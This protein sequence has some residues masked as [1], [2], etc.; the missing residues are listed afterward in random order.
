MIPVYTGILS[1]LPPVLTIVLAIITKEVVVSLLVGIFSGSI[2]YC[3]ATQSAFLEAVKIVFV[4]MSKSI[5]ENIYIIIFG[6]MLGA[7]VHVITIAGGS[8]AYGKWAIEKIKSRKAVQIATAFLGIFLAIDDYFNCL[9]VGTV[10]RPITDKH[11]V[12]RAKFAYI[13]D[14]M[15]APVCVIAPISSWAASIVSCLENAELNGMTM[16]IR[17]IPYNFYAILTICFVFMLCLSGIDFGPMK[18]FEYNALVKGDLFTT[19]PEEIDK[20]EEY[21]YISEKGTVWDLLLPVI[22]L[23][24]V[25][26]LMMLETG[27]FF[28]G[29]TTFYHALGSTNSGLSITVGAVSALLAAFLMFVPRK[30]LSFK[31]FMDGVNQGMKSMVPAF[32]ILAL[33]WTMSDICGELIC[34]GVYISDL[35]ASSNVDPAYIPVFVFLVSG[36]LSFS[37]GTSWGTFGILIPVVA[38][39]CQKFSPEITV[40]ALSATLS[41]AVFGDHCSPISDT[42]VLSSMGAGCNHMDHVSSQMPYA[43]LVAFCSLIGYIL[44]GFTQ[45]AIISVFF[46]LMAMIIIAAVI[47]KKFRSKNINME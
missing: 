47:Y 11:R 1:V 9:T 37:L 43:C 6:S 30:V 26:M 31:V 15:A 22:V 29:G 39:I 44:A 2:I 19:R 23:I 45:S 16:F 46:A 4:V 27:G 25:S 28:K 12:S 34:T 35:T 5:G 36:F 42:M 38:A 40:I 20:E 10:M 8:R 32:L 3:I 17:T 14:A 33:A 41:G 24:L 13:I 18:V 21:S 7:L